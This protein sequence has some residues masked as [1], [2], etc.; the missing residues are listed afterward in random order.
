MSGIIG[1]WYLPV[2]PCVPLW[3]ASLPPTPL[4][5]PHVAAAVLVFGRENAFHDTSTFVISPA[6]VSIMIK[7]GASARLSFQRFLH[8]VPNICES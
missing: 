5:P 7:D 6:F 1:K 8:K 2:P 4:A 3:S